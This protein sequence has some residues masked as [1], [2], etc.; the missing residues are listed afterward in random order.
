MTDEVID[1]ALKEMPP[2]WY[3]LSGP[4]LSQRLKA[5][6]DNLL[7]G[8]DRYYKHLAGDVNVHGTDRNESVRVTRSDDG[9][10][11]VAMAVQG[12]RA[13]FYQRRFE[14]SDTKTV[15]LYLHGGNDEVVSTG[16][17]KGRIKV[18]VIGG[19]GDDTLDD[20]L[21]GKARFYD[22]EGSNNVVKGRGTKVDT[23]PWTNPLPIEEKPWLEPRDH[24]RWTYPFALV[25]AD[26]D[27]GALLRF[28]FETTDWSFRKYPYD[29]TH[30]LEVAYS[31]DRGAAA[32]YYDGSFQK[33]NSHL[34]FDTALEVSGFGAFNFYGFGNDTENPDDLEDDD[35][36][37]V[38]ERLYNFRP[39]VNWRPT[40]GFEAYL[41][42]EFQYTEEK[43]SNT[44]LAQTQPFGAGDFGQAGIILGFEWDS[45]GKDSPLYQPG[46]ERVETTR[47]LTGV[48]LEFQASLFPEVWDVEETFGAVEGRLKGSLAL[49]SSEKIVLAGQVGGRKVWGN[50]PYHEAAYVGGPGS[51]RGYSAQRF[52][53]DAAAYAGVELRVQ[54]FEGKSFFPARVWAFG[55]ADVGRVWSDGND[56]N[57]W[58][59]AYG[60]GI[61]VE[62]PE[63][64]IKLRLEAARNPED[65]DTSVY[66]STGFSF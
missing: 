5:R 20:S 22:F 11:E 21:S 57:D 61:V 49:G 34:S 32:F 17:A 26:P 13:P 16:P 44:L 33:T 7:E 41:G 50:F 8:V 30:R 60:G 6:R 55:L 1:G 65:D 54:V 3:A 29:Q 62:L 40:E 10:V 28:G 45:R 37:E 27:A 52:A 64:P 56:G 18:L 15:R 31:T 23:R 39:T 4:E 63:S 35:F 19:P 66:F 59:E 9:S 51:I 58:H 43:S 25:G 46:S 42:L 53:G 2:E 48:G 47:K 12:Q 36:F 38:E 14:A 24:T